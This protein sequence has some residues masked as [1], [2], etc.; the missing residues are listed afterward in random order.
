[1]ATDVTLVPSDCYLLVHN[2]HLLLIM[3]KWYKWHFCFEQDITKINRPFLLLIDNIEKLSYQAVTI[4]SATKPL[5]IFTI[6][7]WNYTP[8]YM[9]GWCC[10][11]K[12]IIAVSRPF[13][14]EIFAMSFSS[15]L[16][17]LPPSFYLSNIRKY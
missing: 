17:L 6:T 14:F 5:S 9:Y 7:S 13:V 2:T 11:I 12:N 8:V 10:K 15:H 3:E 1:M 16:T 4:Y